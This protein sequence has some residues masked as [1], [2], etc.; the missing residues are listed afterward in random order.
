MAE[1]FLRLA[2]AAAFSM[3]LTACASSPDT[4]FAD[5]LASPSK[6][7]TDRQA[8]LGNEDDSSPMQCVPYARAH[9]GITIFGD[10]WTWWQKAAGKFTRSPTPVL[11]SVM[12]LAG[13]AGPNR[14]HLAVVSAMDTEREI[15]VD[16][17]NWFN[18][19]SILTDDPVVDVSA[20]NDWS[21]VK[22][23][24]PRTNAWG[25]KIYAVEGFIGPGPGGD[26][27]AM[28]AGSPASS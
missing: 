26:V 3:L 7:D 22:V 21:S 4:Y 20:D 11:G 5:D 18:D 25:L 2:V 19:G 23:W 28:L 9:S 6:S 10:A 1:S 15:R 27:V 13:Y 24:N 17:A 8:R 12:V 14:A 16:H